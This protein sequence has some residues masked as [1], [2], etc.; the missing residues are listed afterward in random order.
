M[1]NA[2][3]RKANGMPVD[4][5]KPNE[6]DSITLQELSLYHAITDYRSSLGLDPVRLSKALSAT[7]GRHVVDT[8]ENIW[9]EDV[10]LPAG[11]NN[12]HSWSDAYYYSDQRAPEVM[13]DAPERLGTGYTSAGYEISAAG[14][15]TTDAALAGWK[16]S[17]VAQRGAREHRGLGGRRVSRDRRRR[18]DLAGRGPLRRPHLPCLVR[19]G[20]RRGGSRDHRVRPART[21]SPAPSLMTT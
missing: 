2:A 10:K 16:A 14:Y 8:R 5:K 3:R 20:A 4:V 9:A 13:W 19:R 17:A 1:F 11:A 12:L 18:R 7:A 21:S 15:A 6:H